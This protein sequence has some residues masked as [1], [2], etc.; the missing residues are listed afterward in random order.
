MKMWN[1]DKSILKSIFW[2]KFTYYDLKQQCKA[3]HSPELNELFK[4][5]LLP[6]EPSSFEN[7][8]FE[9]IQNLKH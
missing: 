8:C 9:L 1:S 7:R 5:V 3:D 4:D 2:S 6:I